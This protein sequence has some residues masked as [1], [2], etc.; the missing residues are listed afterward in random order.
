[1]KK[2]IIYCFLMGF[3]LV[4]HSQII[5]VTDIETGEAIEM[6]SLISE[7]PKASTTTNHKGQ[8]DI[9]A[10]VNS[11]KIVI[12]H[13]A[14]KPVEFSYKH[15][16]M[17]GFKVELARKIAVMQEI[18]ISAQRW[19]IK[20]IETPVRIA[21]INVKE[22]AFQNP[23]TTADLLGISGYAFIQKS[24]LGGGSPM[25]RGMAT[26]RVLL[27][28]DGVR[29]NNAIFRSGNLQN[30]ISLDANAIEN[31]D[32]LFG[33][34]SVMY[35]SDAIGGVMSFNTLKPRFSVDSSN[36]PAVTG[37]AMSRFSSANMEK[38]VHFDV[39]VGLKKVAFTSSFTFADYDD[40]R[41]GSVGGVPYFYRNY[42]VI[43]YDNKDYM[44]PNADSTLQVGSEYSQINFMQKVRFQP[45]KFLEIDYG[46]HF[47][48]TSK[49]NR[50]DRLYVMRTDGP[51]K[52]KLRWAEWYYGPQKWQMNRLG[53]TYSKNNRF[54][55]NLRFIAAHQFFEESRYD[56]EFMYRELRMQKEN[57]DAISLNLDF[58]KKINERMTLYYG[59]EYVYNLVHSHA[60]L[61]HVVTKKVDPT[62]TRYPDGSM[63]Q[64][65]GG[66]LTAR[67]KLNEKWLLNAGFRYNQFLITATFDTTFFPFPF[68]DTR[69]KSGAISGSMGFIFTPSEKWQVYVNAANGFRAP[70]VDDM[71]KVFESVPGYLVVPNP[72][73]KPEKVYNLEV[74]TVRTISNFVTFDATVYRTWL[75]DAMVRKNFQ[76]NGD[77]MI[78][79]LGNKS[80]IQAIQNVTEIDVYGF[81]AGIEF[82]YRGFGL[83]SNLSYQKGK[84]QTPDSLVYY[85]LR[86]AAPTFGSTHL[87][88]EYRNKFKVDFYVVYNAKMDYK[89]LALTERTNAS[90]ARDESG[91]AYVLGWTTLNLKMTYFPNPFIAITAGIENITNLL[92]RP[93]ASGINAP[94]RNLITSLRVKF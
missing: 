90:Y 22:A 31:T 5:T 26:N 64:S 59:Y 20:K 54:F 42:Y 87:S 56:R 16:E 49:Y 2:F 38:T 46:F 34:G 4:A 27:V 79:F 8:A 81:Q 43:T 50:Y 24:Q 80:R 35:G 89:D 63:W 86:H 36:K 29:M 17:Q 72:D 58:D 67:Y 48:E 73:L 39:N 40:L 45:C 83:K 25:L 62:V 13:V 92:Y 66:Y 37:N 84:E 19:E 55:D 15:L 41:S 52:G 1:M 3:V 18:K 53:I 78:R 12:S 65:N 70:N 23:Q 76:L 91:R 77:T 10:F 47:S 57:V 21:T 9:S 32:I 7:M 30:V 60:T 71:G 88:Y 69:M 44:I 85:P 68:T 75:V 14:Y 74:G 51:Y 61:T 94:G 82:Y 33:P 11:E 93:Y 28:V 6:A